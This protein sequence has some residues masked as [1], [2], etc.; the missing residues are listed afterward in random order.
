MNQ[1]EIR[2]KINYKLEQ[3]NIEDDQ[4]KKNALLQDLKVLQMRL[5]MEKTHDQ[6]KKITNRE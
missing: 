2:T 1:D 4:N 3:I 6:I 5:D